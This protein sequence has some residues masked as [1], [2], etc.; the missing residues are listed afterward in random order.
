MP[1]TVPYHLLILENEAFVKGDV[2]TGEACVNA[3]G[4][5]GFARGVP[6]AWC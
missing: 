5:S 3:Q 6:S 2:D 4:A 1:T